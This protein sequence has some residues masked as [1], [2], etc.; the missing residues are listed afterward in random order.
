MRFRRRSTVWYGTRLRRVGTA[1]KQ[2]LSSYDRLVEAINEDF[3]ATGVRQRASISSIAV[4]SAPLF[5]P[6]IRYGPR[7]EPSPEHRRDYR[8]KLQKALSA[9][10]E[11]FPMGTAELFSAF[12]IGDDPKERKNSLDLI[13]NRMLDHEDSI[14]LL[15]KRSA[16]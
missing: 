7:K 9:E 6:N 13:V 12:Q 14:P 4:Q 5:I 1:N 10:L 16:S 15:N 2:F 8:D 11:L 3:M